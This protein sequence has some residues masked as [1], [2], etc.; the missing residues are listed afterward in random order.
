MEW[1]AVRLWV[2]RGIGQAPRLCG[3]ARPLQPCSVWER[4]VTCTNLAASES[5]AELFEGDSGACSASLYTTTALTATPI[6]IP[7]VRTSQLST[8]RT[9]VTVL[10][11]SP[12]AHNIYEKV[13]ERVISDA[14]SAVRSHRFD[15]PL[16]FAPNVL[17][18]MCWRDSYL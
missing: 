13:T 4:Q 15:S 9:R 6:L 16:F 10:Q 7:S 1:V 14:N 17:L 5:T 8:L 11:R 18:F 3:A 2:D 12:L